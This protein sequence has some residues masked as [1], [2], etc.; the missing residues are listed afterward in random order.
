MV[1]LGSDQFPAFY[2]RSVA[3][4]LHAACDDA[5]AAAAVLEAT[6]GDLKLARACI[7]N[8]SPQTTRFRAGDRWVILGALSELNERAIVGQAVTPFLL[9]R[10]V[11]QTGG[12][13]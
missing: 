6:W 2:S 1:V 10:I 4:R 12:A 7:A 9:S 13:A 3:T 8:P 5:A 11:E